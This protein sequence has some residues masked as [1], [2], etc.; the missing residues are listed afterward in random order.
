MA[1]VAVQYN[2][3]YILIRT[4]FYNEILRRQ[5]LYGSKTSGIEEKEEDEINIQTNGHLLNY[6]QLFYILLHIYSFHSGSAF[7]ALFIFIR[8]R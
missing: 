5:R 1:P 7:L 4:T 6:L 3:S 2:Y 8:V